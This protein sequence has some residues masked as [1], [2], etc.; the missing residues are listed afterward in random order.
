M[1]DLSEELEIIVFLEQIAVTILC[2]GVHDIP[3]GVGNVDNWK[4]T[5]RPIA[6]VRTLRQHWYQPLCTWTM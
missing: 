4:F 2:L 5:S 3:K 6:P 1:E